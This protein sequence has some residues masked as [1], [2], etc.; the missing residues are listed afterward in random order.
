MST[1]PCSMSRSL[2]GTEGGVETPTS[3]LPEGVPSLPS[4]LPGVQTLPGTG[5]PVASLELGSD[6][7]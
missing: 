5:R 4:R 6:F 2:W 1:G 7:P 3:G